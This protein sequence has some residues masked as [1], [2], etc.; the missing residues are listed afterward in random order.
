MGELVK[1][2]RKLLTILLLTGLTSQS[3]MAQVDDAEIERREAAV[4]F[5]L[6]RAMALGI[7]RLECRQWLAGSDDD[8][9]RVA[10]SWWERNRDELDAA[11][12]I[13]AEAIRRYRSTMPSDK[14][15][16]AERAMVQGM[17][18]TAQNNLRIVFRRQIPTLESCR[19]AIQQYKFSQLDVSRL[20]STK[21]YE[22]FAEFGASLKRVRADKAYQ[23]PEEKFRTL[24]T[25]VSVWPQPLISLD[26]IEAAKEKKDSQSIIRGFESLAERGDRRAAQTLGMSYLNGQYVARN[27]QAATAWFYNAWAMGE[28]DGINALGVIWRD[29]IGV[30]ADRKL[31]LA[32]FAIARQMTFVSKDA[33]FQRSSSNYSQLAAQMDASDVKETSCMKWEVLHNKIREVAAATQSVK[34]QGPPTLPNGSLAETKTLITQLVGEPICGG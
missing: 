17:G 5:F 16:S 26:A 32:A 28:P 21:G 18:D 15:A 29:A 2:F 6:P 3:A 14:A 1:M 23:P 4:G 31:A 33:V 27:T 30:Q 7:L 9:N 19:R 11:A 24:E 8:V 22:Q 20:G 10:Q 25:Q 13:V 34:L 12:W